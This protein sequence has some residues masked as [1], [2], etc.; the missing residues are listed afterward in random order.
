[1]T[2]KMSGSEVLRRYL[3]E[4]VGK[5]IPLDELNKLSAV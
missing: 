3:E 1:M 2:E 4:N 5:E